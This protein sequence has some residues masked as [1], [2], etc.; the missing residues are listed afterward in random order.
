MPDSGG[1]PVGL[2][3]H[4]RA[5]PGAPGGGPEAPRADRRA[6]PTAAGSGVPEPDPGG[7]PWRTGR[8]ASGG[9][10]GPTE[11][12]APS[13]VALLDGSAWKRLSGEPCNRRRQPN[14]NREGHLTTKWSNRGPLWA[15]LP[16]SGPCDPP[17]WAAREVVCHRRRHDHS[18]PRH[19]HL[20][21]RPEPTYRGRLSAIP[22]QWTSPIWRPPGPAESPRKGSALQA[23]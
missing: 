21:W 12:Q 11:H 18:W 2:G 13:P 7:S 3:P 14:R 8:P 15:Q 6:V 9:P 10:W 5:P 19:R 1:P 20:P 22:T 23:V 4:W 16:T 17:S